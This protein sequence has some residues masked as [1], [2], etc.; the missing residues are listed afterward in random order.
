MNNFNDKT[1]KRC[2]ICN[3]VNMSDVSNETSP[4]IKGSF[5]EDG[6]HFL[7]TPCSES[8]Y[9][10]VNYYE[11]ND[12]EDDPLYPQTSPLDIETDW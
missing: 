6:L 12:E 1:L 4:Y 8:V 7:C 2:S 11:K 3:A 9:Y 10:A 5:H